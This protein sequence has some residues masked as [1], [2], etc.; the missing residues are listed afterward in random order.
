MKWQD[1]SETWCPEAKA[2]HWD[3]EER[4]GKKRKAGSWWLMA[5]ERRAPMTGIL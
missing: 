5:T 4:L 2:V 1:R 3:K